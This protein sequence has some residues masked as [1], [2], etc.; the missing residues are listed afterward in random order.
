[1]SVIVVFLA[2]VLVGDAIAV[3]I[4]TI[5]EH[6][7][8]TASLLVFLALFISVFVA[9]WHAAVYVTERYILRQRQS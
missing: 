2:F 7:S 8:N 3:G 1:M 4:A 5:V 6:F 9:A